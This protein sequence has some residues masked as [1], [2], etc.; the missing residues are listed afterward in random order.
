MKIN[1]KQSE[2][3]VSFETK[4]ACYEK[5]RYTNYRA[6]LQLEGILPGK[7]SPLNEDHFESVK[8]AVFAKYGIRK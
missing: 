7:Y 2:N 5:S 3:R 8:T 1:G 4:K 6:S